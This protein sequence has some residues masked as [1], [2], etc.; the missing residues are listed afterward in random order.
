MYNNTALPSP[1]VVQLCDTSG[2]PAEIAG[3]PIS[4]GRTKGFNVRKRGYIGEKNHD[5]LTSYAR[6]FFRRRRANE[7]T[8]W[9]KWIS[10]FLSQA[11]TSERIFFYDVT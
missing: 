2:N 1:L 6:S 7:R 4:L 8:I 10:A 3:V 5:S 11:A 9:D